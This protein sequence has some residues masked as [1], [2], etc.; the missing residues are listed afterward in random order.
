VGEWTR[1][2]D[3]QTI[4][5]R[6]KTAGVAAA[7]VQDVEDQ[8]QRDP[9]AKARGLYHEHEEPEMGKVISEYPPVRLS[10]TPAQI[11]AHAPLF[12]EHTDAVLR[13]LLHLED[14]ELEALKAEGVLD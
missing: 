1:H 6:L 11:Y 3:G 2:Y 5:E 9:H 12:G 8:L 14:A 4:M 13:D 10:E 7:P